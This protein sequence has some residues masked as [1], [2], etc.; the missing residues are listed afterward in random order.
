MRAA[1][2]PLAATAS[3]AFGL[4]AE[5]MA[6]PD[7]I[8]SPGH[9]TGSPDG[10]TWLNNNQDIGFDWLQTNFANPVSATEVRVVFEQ[11]EGT[12]SKIELLDTDG[13][14]HEVWSGLDETED[15]KRGQRTWFVRKF[16]ATPYKAQGVKLTIANAMK[17]G[18]KSIDSVQLVGD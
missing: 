2:G 16:D 18:Y 17:R 9:A 11:G 15:D 14:L 4:T 1:N 3:S 5:E 8:N 13:K 12:V 10:K 6:N 7:K